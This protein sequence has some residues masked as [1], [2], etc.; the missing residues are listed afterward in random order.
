MPR[1]LSV[2]VLSHADK[3]A[4]FVRLVVDDPALASAVVAVG[5]GELLAVKPGHDQRKQCW[6]CRP[7]AGGLPR[8]GG[9]RGPS[10][11]L[12]ISGAGVSGATGSVRRPIGDPVMGRPGKY[13]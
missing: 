4:P 7:G 10:R 1:S 9:G 8:P 12:L 6:C 13:S 3:V 2:P 11:G 5:K